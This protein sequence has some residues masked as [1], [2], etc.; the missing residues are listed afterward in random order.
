M[1]EAW[2]AQRTA[3]REAVRAFLSA[4]RAV[5]DRGWEQPLAT[6][7]WTPAQ[8]AEHLRLTYD[9]LLRETETGAP[10][11]RRRVP[12]WM[13]PLLRWK[14]LGIVLDDGHMPPGARAPR[15]I[16]P[17]PGPFDRAHTLAEV[18]RLAAAWEVAFDAREARGGGTLT[19]HVFG[20]LR[21]GDAARF[22]VVHTAHHARQLQGP[23]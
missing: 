17:G 10:Q 18:E 23:A 15:E 16:A 8:V 4:A 22:V 1:A 3:H 5:A 19:H 11:L 13:Q 21:A 20:R 6:G 7:K 9:A 12:W 14:F 2:P